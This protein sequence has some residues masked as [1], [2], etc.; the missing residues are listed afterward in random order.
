MHRSNIIKKSPFEG[1]EMSKQNTAQPLREP[2]QNRNS[3]PHQQFE[4]QSST[5]PSMTHPQSSPYRPPISEAAATNPYLYHTAPSSGVVVDLSQNPPFTANSPPNVKMV[6]GY[7]P[8]NLSNNL[9]HS[10]GTSV[11]SAVASAPVIPKDLTFVSLSGPPSGRVLSHPS[12]AFMPGSTATTTTSNNSDVH[13][14]S[15]YDGGIND[16]RRSSAIGYTNSSS[17]GTN[18]NNIPHNNIISGT[19]GG[20][21][22]HNA[23]MI[24]LPSPAATHLSGINST[25]VVTQQRAPLSQPFQRISTS[26]L[27]AS[28][29]RPTSVGGIEGQMPFIMNNR[30]MGEVVTSMAA[31]VTGISS[32]D[33]SAMHS[34]FPQTVTL[35]RTYFAVSHA[36]VRRKLFRIFLPPVAT[37]MHHKST[38]DSHA[39]TATAGIMTLDPATSPTE[40]SNLTTSN[41]LYIP[42]MAFITYVLLVGLTRGTLDDFHPELLTSTSSFAGVCIILEVLIAKGGF[43]LLSGGDGALSGAFPLLDLISV[44][45]SKFVGLAIVT[46]VGLFTKDTHSAVNWVVFVYFSLCSALHVLSCVRA[47]SSC[48][49]QHTAADLGVKQRLMS[50]AQTYL[51][52]SFAAV[53]VPLCWVLLPSWRQP[54]R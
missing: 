11:T 21:A 23:S 12:P 16:S 44:S 13:G 2:F 40:K 5:G 4:A 15:F 17:F 36:S 3:N 18:F 25:Q 30:L 32:Q 34:W 53:Q 8:G 7:I 39:S 50:T 33:M 45:G 29:S 31:N 26:S 49:A 51:C 20:S 54:S 37:F 43:Y 10:I 19:F 9:N 28:D 6:N 48:S 1:S 24:G 22:V 42:L 41:D 47:I 38:T 14:L 46:L 27:E 52:W 35:L